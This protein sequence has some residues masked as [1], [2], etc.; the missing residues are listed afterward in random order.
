MGIGNIDI[1]R[2]VNDGIDGYMQEL[3]KNANS[4]I[5]MVEHR[6]KFGSPPL[7]VPSEDTAVSPRAALDAHQQRIKRRRQLLGLPYE[8]WRGI[9]GKS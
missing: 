7:L 1:R 8:E 5:D 3:Q 4:V 2:R 9:G 6:I